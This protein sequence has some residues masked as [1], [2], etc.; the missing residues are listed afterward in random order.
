MTKPKITGRTTLA[1]KRLKKF[2]DD[3]LARKRSGATAVRPLDTSSE[4]VIDCKND[5]GLVLLTPKSEPLEEPGSGVG[6]V[7]KEHQLET[8][9]NTDSSLLRPASVSTF[10]RTYSKKKPLQ[11]YASQEQ[12]SVNPITPVEYDV[13]TIN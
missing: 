7:W 9:E 12:I 3:Y 13:S 10:L 1:A 11:P 2:R 5:G 4:S 8:A 6:P